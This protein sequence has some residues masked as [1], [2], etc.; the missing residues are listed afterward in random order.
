MFPALA[1]AIVVLTRPGYSWDVLSI[2]SWNI[3]FPE[4]CTT[5]LEKLRLHFLQKNTKL[6]ESGKLVAESEKIAC[7]VENSRRAITTTIHAITDFIVKNGVSKYIKLAKKD[8]QKVLDEL[9][10]NQLLTKTELETVIALTET[11]ANTETVIAIV[12]SASK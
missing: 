10:Y 1:L 7:D 9:D 8:L 6:S 11:K 4:Y 3:V 5:E 2:S 12:T